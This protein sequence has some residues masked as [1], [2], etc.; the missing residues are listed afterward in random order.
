VVGA[1][2]YNVE[3]L[4]PGSQEQLSVL[5]YLTTGQGSSES[6]PLKKA[7][8]RD[9][10]PRETAKMNSP[11]PVRRGGWPQAAILLRQPGSAES[12]PVPDAH[13]ETSV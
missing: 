11:W 5:R 8:P 9:A 7:A 1:A 2:T 13:R 10:D 4:E 3:Q 6:K 12:K